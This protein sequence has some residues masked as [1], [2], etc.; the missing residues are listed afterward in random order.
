MLHEFRL[1]VCDDEELYIDR[2]CRH[3]EIYERESGNRL[4]VEPYSSAEALL[5]EFKGGEKQYDLLFLDV[6]MPKMKGTDAAL[7]VRDYDQTIPICFI[8]S[9]EEYAFAAFM[10]DA[11]GYL[12][13]PV[14]YEE[15]K[16]IV[17]KCIA[18]IHYE[19]DRKAAEEQYICVR[20]GN[21]EVMLSVSDIQYIEKQ[22]N[23][24]VFFLKDCEITCYDTLAKVYEKLNHDRF[25]YT[26]QG[27][28]V[29][30][31]YIRQVQPDRIYLAGN[32]EIPVSRKYYK[33][34]QEL[35][36]DKLKRL[37]AEKRV[38]LETGKVQRGVGE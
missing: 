32:R 17:D 24:C 6:D 5:E 10:A 14:K 26:H 30:F 11:V 21:G 33:R 7:L 34:L 16:R 1:A 36:R 27:Y 4:I 13:K 35:H 19:R 2:I 12:V 31:A 37:L 15:L 23:R 25:Y 8:T 22:R 9:Y 29:N 18:Q 20:R 3:L 28:I 38:E